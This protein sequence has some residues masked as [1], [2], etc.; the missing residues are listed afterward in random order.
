M[1]SRGCFFRC[2]LRALLSIFE[3]L[4][5][6]FKG[7]LEIWGS[8]RRVTRCQGFPADARDA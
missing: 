5:L 7:V 8:R 6:F 4:G 1:A 2:F 3:L